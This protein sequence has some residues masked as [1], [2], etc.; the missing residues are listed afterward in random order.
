MYRIIAVIALFIFAACEFTSPPSNDLSA[1]DQGRIIQEVETSLRNYY[2]DV[3]IKGIQAEFEYLDTSSNFYW[4]PPDYE[5]WI[6]YDSVANVILD[7]S[8]K[9]SAVENYWESLRI[10][11]LSVKYASYSGILK[12][13]TSGKDGNVVEQRFMETGIVVKREDGWKLLRGQTRLIE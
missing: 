8:S 13:K 4:I 1:E 6:N 9:I 3:A 7:A 12:G 5:N 2:R 11:P 10:D